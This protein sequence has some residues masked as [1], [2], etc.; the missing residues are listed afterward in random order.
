LAATNRAKR[1][2][3]PVQ[4]FAGCF[5]LSDDEQGQVGNKNKDDKDDFVKPEERVHDYVEGLAR[6]VKPFAVHTVYKILGEET[7]HG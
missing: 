1:N 7:H 2:S 6:H 5:F 3:R 4:G